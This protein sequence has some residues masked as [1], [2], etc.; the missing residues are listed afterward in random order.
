MSK[1]IPI[2]LIANTETNEAYVLLPLTYTIKVSEDWH[3]SQL[4]MNIEQLEELY[5]QVQEAIMWSK[6]PDFIGSNE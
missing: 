5:E 6:E 3:G 4:E 1:R 2:G